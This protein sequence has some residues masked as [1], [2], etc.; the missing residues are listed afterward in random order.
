[1]SAWRSQESSST[2]SDFQAVSNGRFVNGRF[3]QLNHCCPTYQ[4][5][6]P[7][8]TRFRNPK[9]PFQGNAGKFRE[10]QRF[11]LKNTGMTKK[12]RSREFREIRSGDPERAF[13]DDFPWDAA[14]FA[15]SWKLPAYS[16]AFLL[17]VDN[18]SS[19]TYRWS[20]FFGLQLELFAYSGKVRLLSALRDCKQRSLTVSKK[21]PTVSKKASPWR[22]R[23][24]KDLM[25]QRD[26]NAK[27]VDGTHL[28]QGH[29]W[30]QTQK[31]LEVCYCPWGCHPDPRLDPVLGPSRSHPGS[32]AVPSRFAMCFVF[33]HFGPIQVPRWG[34]S[35]PV[36]VPSCSRAF[37]PGSG[38]GGP[39]QTSRPLPTNP[40][41]SLDNV[42]WCLCCHDSV[43]KRLSVWPHSKDSHAYQSSILTSERRKLPTLHV[44][45]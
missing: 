26:D 9:S 33:Q 6:L 19:L 22:M 27:H 42:T 20:F 15:Y 12:G 25:K 34:P 29:I 36:L 31:G 23:T 38:L 40:D 44:S 39:K 28:Q 14:F 2:W 16:G 43:T 3:S 4:L 1:M 11:L 37:L 13:W 24:A 5:H 18:F 21:A 7:L 45:L 10:I 17:T 8:K 41:G 32:E 30:S 35:R